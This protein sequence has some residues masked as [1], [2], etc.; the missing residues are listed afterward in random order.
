MHPER[1]WGVIDVES[2]ASLTADLRLTRY[3][4]C[5]GFR[6][7]GYLFLNDSI[8]YDPDLI[9]DYAIV[10]ERDLREVDTVAVSECSATFLLEVVTQAIAGDLD[11][12]YD[13]V[14]H[15]IGR[16]QIASRTDHECAYCRT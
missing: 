16:G 5:S 9:Q 14:D 11:E 12:S 4:C 15:A 1:C 2:A 6:L 3:A 8:D 13:A 10:R 7:D